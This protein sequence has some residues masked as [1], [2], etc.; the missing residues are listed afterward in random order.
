[1]SRVLLNFDLLP[2]CLK[3]LQPG[4]WDAHAFGKWNI[5]LAY[6]NAAYTGRGFDAFLGTSGNLK[7]TL[8][9]LFVKGY[10]QPKH[11]FAYWAHR[12]FAHL[13]EGG[14]SMPAVRVHETSCRLC[15]VHCSLAWHLS[16]AMV[17]LST[18]HFKHSVH[19]HLM[20][21]PTVVRCRL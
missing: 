21:C 18:D 19:F 8:Y 17:A 3:L 10:R 6:G 14:S 4:R 16:G 5:G 12:S 11:V 7:D 20:E 2:A 9:H 1:M 13:G 15:F